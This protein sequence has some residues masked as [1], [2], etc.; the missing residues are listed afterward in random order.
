ME[1]RLRAEVWVKAYVR[2]C[3]VHGASAFIVAR[4]DETAGAVIVKLNYLNGT[5]TVFSPTRTGEGEFVWLRALGADPVAETEADAYIARQ[6]RFDPDL[7]IVE[8]EDR[9]G[10]HFLDGVDAS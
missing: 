9:Q 2:R 7:W 6:Q 5:A 8:V 10:R 4:G 3:E 1:P